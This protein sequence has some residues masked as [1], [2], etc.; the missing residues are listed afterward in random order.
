MRM[1]KAIIIA[2]VLLFVVSE[3]YARGG[4]SSGGRSSSSSS[5]GRSSSSASRS[6]SSSYSSN[7]SGTSGT[8]SSGRTAASPSSSS[9]STANKSTN[10]NKTPSTNYNTTPSTNYN[11]SPSSNRSTTGDVL[12]SPVLWYAVGN[13]VGHSSNNTVPSSP[14]PVQVEQGSQCVS[15]E[16]ALP[17]PPKQHKKVVPV[18]PVTPVVVNTDEKKQEEF[19]TVKQIKP[20]KKPF[21][22]LYWSAMLGGTG[23]LGYLLWITFRKKKDEYKRVR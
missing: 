8:S 7:K 5:S 20:K 15:R 9:T 18:N 14:A 17:L 22:W 1:S 13:A 10:Y 23:I 4:T 19:D 21:N 3:I 16:A 6:S 2:M 11:T 12:G